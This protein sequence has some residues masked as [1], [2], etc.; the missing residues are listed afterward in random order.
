MYPLRHT[1]SGPL[2]PCKREKIPEIWV[3]YTTRY[4]YFRGPL[5]YLRKSCLIGIL[6]DFPRQELDD[7]F[8]P[9]QVAR[10]NQM[11]DE[12]APGSE[13]VIIGL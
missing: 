5:I 8:C 12:Q 2:S 13:T 1:K 11:A 4:P 10:Q 9:G 7:L 3:A 6:R